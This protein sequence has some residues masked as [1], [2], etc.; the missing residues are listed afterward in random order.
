MKGTADSLEV[1]EYKQGYYVLTDHKSSGSYKVAKW[2][3]VVSETEEETLLDEDGKP[4]LLK[5]GK[6]KGQPK[7]RQKRTIVTDPKKVEIL[8]EELQINRY[9][10]WFEQKGF[11]V[12]RMQIQAI[13]R[14]GNTYVA[15]N[16]G[17]TETLYLIPIRRIP[18]KEVLDFYE[19]LSD[20]VNEG[21]KTGYVRECNDWEAWNN[22]RRCDKFCE[23]KD[24]CI[25]MSKKARERWGIL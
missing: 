20:E 14:D 3:G 19:K 16:R 5:S 15:T 23:V 10:I 24:A 17:I 21:F 9:R 11:P 22:R 8:A 25:E 7:T 18:N 4:I 6:N 13:P 1:D 12:S 2:L